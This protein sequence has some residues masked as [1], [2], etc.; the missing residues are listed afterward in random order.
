M[1]QA[2]MLAFWDDYWFFNIVFLCLLPLVFLKPRSPKPVAV[3]D[4]GLEA[5]P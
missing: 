2:K 1:R 5:L 3:E 4:P